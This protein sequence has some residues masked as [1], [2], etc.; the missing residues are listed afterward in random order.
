MIKK[1]VMIA[2]VLLIGHIP[3][4]AVELH[5]GKLGQ[6]LIRIAQPDNWTGN[7]LLLA[8]GYRPTEADMSAD[9]SLDGHFYKSMLER[10][11]LIAATSY[12]RNGFVLDDAVQDIELLRQEV[13]RRYQNKGLTLVSGN[14]MGGG[15]VTMIAESGNTNYDGAL[16]LGA[17][18]ARNSPTYQAKIPL[19]F[20]SNRSELE[21]PTEYVSKSAKAPVVPAVWSIDR[22]GHV[23]VGHE[24]WL[25]AIDGLLEFIN[26]GKIENGKDN[27]IRSAVT[28]K[29]AFT[30][31]GALTKVTG[32]NASF[33]NLET[34]FT[35]ED[36]DAIDVKRG[37]SFWVSFNEKTFKV[38]YGTTYS[39]VSQGEW[40]AFIT[41]EATL[42][43]ARN[44]ES[45]AGAL[46]CQIGDTIMI[47][48]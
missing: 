5:E 39:D 23:N 29:A 7:V 31:D 4:L 17:Y 25:V 14:S 12:R 15:I 1:H 8:H 40:V 26:T 33:G 36:L 48:R 11:W 21:G 10:G 20:V 32:I 45:A 16:A 47:T 43:I 13:S 19:L 41:A 6:S 30:A 28:S 35:S 44:Y 37:G 18:L 2:L 27:T 34:E 22:D 9:F 42:R 24:E 38:F 3:V 46:G